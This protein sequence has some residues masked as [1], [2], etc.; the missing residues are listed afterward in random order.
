MESEAS[1]DG[2]REIAILCGDSHT[3]NLASTTHVPDDVEIIDTCSH[4]SEISPNLQE[5]SCEQSTAEI[6]QPYDSDCLASRLGLEIDAALEMEMDQ[7]RTGPGPRI[8][9]SMTIRHISPSHMSIIIIPS[10]FAQS[11][12]VLNFL[13]CLIEYIRNIIVDHLNPSFHFI[14]PVFI[15]IDLRI[16]NIGQPA[17]GTLKSIRSLIPRHPTYQAICLSHIGPIWQDTTF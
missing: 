17:L 7:C 10:R 1:T 5:Y 16:I 14:F 11:D 9:V 4:E 2:R 3:T 6:A 15:C 13:S 12:F 8:I